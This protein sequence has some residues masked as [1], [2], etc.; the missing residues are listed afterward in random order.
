MVVPVIVPAITVPVTIV[1]A[2]AGVTTATGDV[3]VI[4]TLLVAL[5]FTPDIVLAGVFVTFPSPSGSLP[6]GGVGGDA[7]DGAG[8]NITGPT[9][10][11]NV[12][13]P[14]GKRCAPTRFAN[15][16][17]NSNSTCSDAAS[18]HRWSRA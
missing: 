2:P 5:I 10:D 11:C 15:R 9:G 12:V 18:L 3:S 8:A 4:L 1:P 7:G 6:T 16:A 14:D 13:I 17:V